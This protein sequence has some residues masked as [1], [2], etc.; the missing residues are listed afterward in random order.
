MII[1]TNRSWSLTILGS[2]RNPEP[3]ALVGPGGSERLSRAGALL[4]GARHLFHFAPIDGR[5]LALAGL[6]GAASTLWPEA[7]KLLR[8]K[9]TPAAA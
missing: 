5:D 8:R 9:G 4:A 7:L 2:L 6:A 3:G 1:L